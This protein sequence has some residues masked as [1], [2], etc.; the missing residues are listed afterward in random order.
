[1]ASTRYEDR[2]SE[3]FGRFSRLVYIAGR[4][5]NVEIP[6]FSG[7]SITGSNHAI[8]ARA[9]DGKIAPWNPAV[10]AVHGHLAAEITG[11]CIPTE[12]PHV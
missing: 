10:E 2:G 9:P 8:A 5:Q 12:V 6:S 3:D 4:K 11:R 1:M 7:T